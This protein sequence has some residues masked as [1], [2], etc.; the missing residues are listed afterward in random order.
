M[1]WHW[2]TRAHETL[3]GQCHEIF[4]FY[5]NFRKNSKRSK[6]DALGLGGNWFM[7]KTWSKKSRDTVSLIHVCWVTRNDKLWILGRI[8]PTGKKSYACLYCTFKAE[9][10][11]GLLLYNGDREDGQGDFMAIFLNQGFL[12]FAFDVGNG[13]AIARYHAPT[14]NVFRFLN[15]KF[16]SV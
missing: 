16:Y 5:E 4:D 7:K 6:W 14:W 2:V 3:K 1:L 10:D 13:V 12:E 9:S 15:L 11:E 8:K